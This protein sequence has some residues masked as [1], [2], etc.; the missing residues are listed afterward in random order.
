MNLS[1]TLS[2]NPIPSAFLLPTV[3]LLR[4]CSGPRDGR[5]MNTPARVDSVAQ[6]IK[7]QQGNNS[8]TDLRAERR[9]QWTER[10]ANLPFVKT[11]QHDSHWTM[12]VMIVQCGSCGQ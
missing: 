3:G 8:D 2:L 9:P 6:E 10:R 4:G 11:V 12:I 5:H 1:F 7:P